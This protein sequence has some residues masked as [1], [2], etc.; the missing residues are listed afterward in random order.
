MEKPKSEH[1]ERKQGKPGNQQE[2]SRCIVCGTTSDEEILLKGER[3]GKP[4]D[5]CVKCLPRLIHG[6]H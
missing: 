2:K 6:Q 5:V 3:D 4:A 1:E